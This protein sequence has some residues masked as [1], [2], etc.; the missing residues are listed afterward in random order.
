VA[1]AFV[2]AHQLTGLRDKRVQSRGMMR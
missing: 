1:V 2:D